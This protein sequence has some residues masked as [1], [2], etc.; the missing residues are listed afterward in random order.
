MPGNGVKSQP[1]SIPICVAISIDD[2]ADKVG[3]KTTTQQIGDEIPADRTCHDH[4]PSARGTADKRISAL[5]GSFL[6][7]ECHHITSLS[8]PRIQP[9]EQRAQ[10]VP[11]AVSSFVNLNTTLVVP[12]MMA[13]ISFVASIPTKPDQILLFGDSMRNLY[14][15]VQLPSK[16]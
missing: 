16:F 10:H 9:K 1:Q 8:S 4:V 5:L 14:G 11:I 12:T 7:P 13:K 3:K 2:R 15:P 6:S